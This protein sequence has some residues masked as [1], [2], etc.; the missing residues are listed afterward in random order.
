MDAIESH[1]DRAKGDHG[2]DG[3]DDE[4]RTLEL[5]NKLFWE[6]EQ[7]ANKAAELVVVRV[8]G[9][10]GAEKILILGTARTTS[11]MMVCF[12]YFTMFY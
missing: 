11:T 5:Q 12:F 4:A 6:V 8:K 3:Q 1:E 2:P 9:L 7:H 10:P